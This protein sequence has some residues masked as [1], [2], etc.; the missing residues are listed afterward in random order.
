MAEDM[1]SAAKSMLPKIRENLSR[2]DSEC[3]LPADLAEAMAEKG[4]FGLY[5]P[6]ILGGPELDPITAFPVVETISTVDGSAGWCC[7]NGTALTSAISRISI[8]AAKELFGDP[9]VIRGSGSARS[10]GTAT[11]TDGGYIVS[12][13]WNYLSG[14]DHAK[15]LFLNCDLVD[16]KGP[17]LAADGSPVSRVVVV[18]VG[19]GTVHIV[20]NTMGMRGTASNDAS[21]SELFVPS[22]HTYERAAPAVHD[23][24]LYNPNT[25]LLLSWTLAAANALG[26]ARGAM[27][28]FMGLATG[29]TT[30]SPRLLRDRETVQTTVGECEAVIGAGRA[31]VLDAVGRMWESQVA[32]SPDLMQKAAHAR[33]A[34]AH[35][36]RQSVVVVDKLFYA[37]GTGAIHESNG[38][39]RYFRDLHVSGQH[40]S[41]LHS[42][43]QL[44]GQMLLGASEDPSLTI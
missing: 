27:D 38:I 30:Q 16:E 22:S 8:A 3:Q 34:I 14:V 24:P 2:I 13:R 32:K 7:F 28:A 36:I 20:W 15:C 1:L 11:V 5:V 33:L 26:M 17:V 19:D 12:G 4:L 9:P 18:P 42:N 37:A 29:R 6:K 40:I 21:Y 39:E 23:S 41:G 44:S 10:G 43:Y 35:A 25:S 31:Y